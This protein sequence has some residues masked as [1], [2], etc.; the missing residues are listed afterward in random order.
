MILDCELIE[1]MHTAGQKSHEK[2]RKSQS[3]KM[4]CSINAGA[5]LHGP[6][7]IRCENIKGVWIPASARYSTNTD[8]SVFKRGFKQ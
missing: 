5:R 4:A 1:A 6:G 3:Y 7:T 2:V 8:L